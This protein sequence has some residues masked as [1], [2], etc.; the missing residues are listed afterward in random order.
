MTD[1]GEASILSPDAGMMILTWVTF[2]ILL[3]ILHK[4][5]WRPILS[6]LDKREEDLRK[7]VTHADQLKDELAKI[8]QKHDKIIAEADQKAQGIVEQSRKAAIEA[9]DIIRRKAKE[10]AQISLENALRDIKD[11]KENALAVLRDESARIAVL[12][13]GK[14]IEENLDDDKNRRLVTQIIKKI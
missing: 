11:E 8:Q 14:L 4:F 5:A 2:L 7:A 1:T 12:L 3:T 13:A 9:A 6:L 10:D